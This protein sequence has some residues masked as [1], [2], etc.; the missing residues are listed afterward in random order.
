MRIPILFVAAVALGA[1][2]QPPPAPSPS[3]ADPSD[4][5][6]LGTVD[7]ISDSVEQVVI[8]QAKDALGR[9]ALGGPR[10]EISDIDGMPILV[11]DSAAVAPMPTVT[12][13]GFAPDMPV[14]PGL[15]G[16]GRTFRFRGPSQ[17][18]MPVVPGSP[19]QRWYFS[20]PDSA[21][22]VFR[23]DTLPA[24]RVEPGKK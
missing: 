21:G 17:P 14:I 13:P 24:P 1:C 16:E 19:G 18:S 2:T 6:G 3:P 12:M 9:M 11:P 20:V 10:V 8:A 4:A 15:P 22:A 5:A 7:L 23:V